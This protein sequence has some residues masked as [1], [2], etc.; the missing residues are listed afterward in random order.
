MSVPRLA[1]FA[2]APSALVP[3]RRRGEMPAQCGELLKRGCFP[4]A[5]HPTSTIQADRSGKAFSSE[6]EPVRV[7]KTRQIKKIRRSHHFRKTASQ[8]GADRK[9]VAM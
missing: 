8:N 9:P 5:P 4:P 1:T 3:E 2:V 7:K 6:V